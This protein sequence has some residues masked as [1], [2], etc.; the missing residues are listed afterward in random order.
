MGRRESPEVFP[1]PL[2]PIPQAQRAETSIAVHL[3]FTAVV[4]CG[5]LRK[6]AAGIYAAAIDKMGLAVVNS[7]RILGWNLLAFSAA[8]TR[9]P[10]LCL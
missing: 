6:T 2:A 4:S 10:P 9:E 5:V 1:I 3:P 8:I 7:C